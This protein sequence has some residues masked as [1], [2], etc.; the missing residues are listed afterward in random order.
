MNTPTVK[1]LVSIPD[2]ARFDACT[3]CF[4][5]LRVGFPTANIHVDI[6]YC[7]SVEDGHRVAE[8]ARQAGCSTILLPYQT[9]LADWEQRKV[10]G[11][12]GRT[13]LVLMDADTIFWKSCEDWEFPGKLMAG[14]YVPRIWNDFAKCVSFPRLHTSM[15]WFPDTLALR[16]RIAAAYPYALEEAGEYCPCNPFMGTVQFIGGRPFFWDCCANLFQMLGHENCAPLERKHLDCFDHLNSASFY[17]VMMERMDDNRGF[18]FTHNEL[19][20]TPEKLRNLWPIIDSYYRQKEI[21]GNLIQ[22]GV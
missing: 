1:I 22:P 18:A 3:L 13:P 17:D 19:V 6:N 14:Y 12:D 20:K 7:T 9:H 4:D 11:H 5:T 15:L 16:M 2:P 8:K 21:E 10:E